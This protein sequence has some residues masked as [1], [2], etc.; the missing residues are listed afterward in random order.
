MDEHMI[1]RDETNSPGSVGIRPCP[2]C[3]TLLSCSDVITPEYIGKA[4]QC[5]ECGYRERV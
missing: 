4:L 2:V 5:D 1:A 3:P